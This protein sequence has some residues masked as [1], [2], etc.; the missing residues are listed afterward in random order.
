MTPG[1]RF[2]VD[3]SSIKG[4]SFGGAKFWA[5]VVD[6]HSSYYWS[7]FLKKKDEWENKIL[8]LIEEFVN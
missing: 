1:E 7:C 6:D 4:T 5:L 3:M 8:D 2:Y